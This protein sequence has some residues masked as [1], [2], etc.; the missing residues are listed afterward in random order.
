MTLGSDPLGVVRL[1]L[2]EGAGL[3]MVAVTAM[4]ALTS[5][6]ACFAPARRAARVNPVALSEQ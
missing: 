4:L 5:M 6:I 1:V 3:V 2:R